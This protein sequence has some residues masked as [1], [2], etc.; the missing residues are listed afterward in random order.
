TPS[1]WMTEQANQSPVF[2]NKPITTIPHGLDLDLFSPRDRAGCRKALG[3][4]PYSKVMIFSSAGDL[5]ICPW[6]GGPLLVDILKS[7]DAKTKNPIEMLA[8][9]KGQLDVSRQLENLKVHKIGYVTSERFMSML[10][11]AADLFIYPTRA[12]SFGLVLAESIACGTPAVTF[13]IGGCGDIIKEGTSGVTVPPFHVDT[14]ADKT[15]ELLEDEDQLNALS[16]SSR[17]FATKHF[18]LADMAKAH[19]DHFQ[20][21]IKEKK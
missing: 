14:F 9:G 5:D 7:I 15:L 13:D 19:Y 2:E 17:R 6:K 11:S 1:K 8:V 20:S 21:I 4:S 3:I 10:L 16:T 18:D 12:D